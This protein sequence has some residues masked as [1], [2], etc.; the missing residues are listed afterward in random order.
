M[1]SNQ[2]KKHVNSNNS[3]FNTVNSSSSGDNLES[4]MYTAPDMSFTAIKIEKCNVIKGSK[5]TILTIVDSGLTFELKVTFDTI[6]NI[7]KGIDL[8]EGE[9][10]YKKEGTYVYNQERKAYEFTY[11]D[12]R[13]RSDLEYTDSVGNIIAIRKDNT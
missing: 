10:G 1:V 11:F 8:K 4:R 6:D 12:E 13:M 7:N 5:E 9:T 2:G 3:G